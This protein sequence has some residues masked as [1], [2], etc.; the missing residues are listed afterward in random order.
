MCDEEINFFRKKKVQFLDWLNAI[1]K[2]I[3]DEK[4]SHIYL[5]DIYLED[6]MK[7]CFIS[8]IIRWYVLK[9]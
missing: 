5:E 3:I 6:Q 9:S 4:I 2:K 8:N 7:I 1:Y